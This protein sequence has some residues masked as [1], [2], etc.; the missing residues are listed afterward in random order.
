MKAKVTVTQK[1]TGTTRS[2]PAGD[3]GTAWLLSLREIFER[4]SFVKIV[5]G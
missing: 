5:T 1:K 3:A 4:A 2:Y